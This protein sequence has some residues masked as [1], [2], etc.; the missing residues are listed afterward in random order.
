MC[1]RARSPG[2]AGGVISA[3]RRQNEIVTAGRTQL[4]EHPVRA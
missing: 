3:T 2:S 1:V 4:T